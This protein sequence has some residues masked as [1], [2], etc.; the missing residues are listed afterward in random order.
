MID[1]AQPVSPLMDGDVKAMAFQTQESAPVVALWKWRGNATEMLLPVTNAPVR[2]VDLMGHDVALRVEGGKL[3][4]PITDSPVFV[5]GPSGSAI[6]FFDWIKA[7]D[8]D[9]DPVEITTQMSDARSI[10]IHIKNNLPHQVRAELSVQA[11]AGVTAKLQQ[12]SLDLAAGATVGAICELAGVDQLPA[13]DG[14]SQDLVLAIK[15][16]GKEFKRNLAL[17]LEP[18]QYRTVDMSSSPD[19]KQWEGLKQYVM[20]KR[21]NVL[22]PDPDLGWRGPDD[23]SVTASVAWDSENFYLLA[24]VRDDVFFQNETGS[25]IWRGDSLQIAFNTMNDAREGFAVYS[26]TDYE[27]AV[28]LTKG[29]PTVA[30]LYGPK[31]VALGVIIT[32]KANIQRVPGGVAYQVAFPWREIAPLAAT[33]GRIFAFNFIA[34]DNDGGGRRFW[35]GLTPGIGDMK[36]PAAYR[37]FILKP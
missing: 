15:S 33:K 19:P 7:A 35:C 10:T 18:C 32:V 22:P 1:R 11:P 17:A 16:D 34:N 25:N 12:G 3:H 29:G 5:A 31:G 2:L 30:R 37:K 36:N 23:L 21:E 13:G 28:A 6:A 27:F 26:P 14:A 20:D 24:N 8:V 9:V 4:I